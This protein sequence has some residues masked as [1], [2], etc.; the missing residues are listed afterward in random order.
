MNGLEP[1]NHDIDRKKASQGFTAKV[2]H[3]HL[4]QF[5]KELD[6]LLRSP[7]DLKHIWPKLKAFA[8]FA[9]DY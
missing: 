6:D 7:K 9:N 2:F 4:R 8:N 1:G 5:P 3:K